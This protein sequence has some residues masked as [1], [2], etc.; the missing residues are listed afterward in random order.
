M[1]GSETTSILRQASG[2]SNCLFSGSYRVS[3]Y[4]VLGYLLGPLAYASI[5][6]YVLAG[7]LLEYLKCSVQ[8]LTGVI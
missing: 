5:A 7:M 6:I 4:P 2:F 1:E 8:Q 3:L